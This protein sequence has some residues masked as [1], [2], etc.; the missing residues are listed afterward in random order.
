NHANA[1]G[2]RIRLE[3][4]VLK[5]R[6]LSPAPDPVIY[7][8]GG[9]GGRAVPDISFNAGIFDFLRDRRDIVLFDQRASGLSARTVA[10]TNTLA[11]DILDLAGVKTQAADGDA[12]PDLIALCLKE[13][14]DGG[15][16]VADYNTTQN[17]YDVRA[18]MSALGYPS[19]NLYGISYGTKLGLEILRRAPEGV[20]AAVL[21][22]ISPPD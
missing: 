11:D 4:A 1:A 5:A 7:L 19:Y 12:E 16:V 15:T 21:D 20:R 18:I 17:A 3:F 6:S 9:P 13:V 14:E 8:H 10:C 2:N 22:S